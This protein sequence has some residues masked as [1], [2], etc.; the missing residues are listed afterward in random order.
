MHRILAGLPTVRAA[1]VGP[2]MARVLRKV[3][4]LRAPVPKVAS[5][6]LP[7]MV[8]AAW[9]PPMVWVLLKAG[10]LKAWVPK[11]MVLAKAMGKR[12]HLSLCCVASCTPHTRDCPARSI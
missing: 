8:Q 12:C 7:P 3:A 6:R 4:A 9:V 5:A 10:A 11:V 1:S 2:A